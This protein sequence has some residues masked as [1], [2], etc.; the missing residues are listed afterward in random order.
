ML[1][2]HPFETMGIYDVDFT[3]AWLS[4]QKEGWGNVL[5]ICIAFFCFF[6]FLLLFPGSSSK[7][8]K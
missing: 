1:K 4:P 5:V 2:K 3:G 6:S 8:S 7:Q